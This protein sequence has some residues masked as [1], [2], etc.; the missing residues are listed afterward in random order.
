MTAAISAQ[1]Q[2]MQLNPAIEWGPGLGDQGAAAGGGSYFTGNAVQPPRALYSHDGSKAQRMTPDAAAKEPNQD[3][4]FRFV[5]IDDHYFT[6]IAVSDLQGKAEYRPLTL[7]GPNNTQRRLLAYTL[8]PATPGQPLKFFVGPKQFDELRSLGPDFT[9]AIDFG[10]FAIIVVP[11]L[12]ALKWLFGFTG[13]Y[14]WSIILLTVIINLVMFPLRHRGSIA[15]RKMQ[16]IQPQMKAIQDRY[17][18]LKMTDPARQKMQEEVSALYR[19][20]GVN[21]ASGC[22]PMLLPCPVLIAL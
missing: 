5:G 18:H 22:V 2:G 19:D 15:M 7:P 20:R 12:N 1:R 11:L 17:A 8:K 6:A 21:P 13:N 14:G 10:W 3:G 16:A 4:P 9:R